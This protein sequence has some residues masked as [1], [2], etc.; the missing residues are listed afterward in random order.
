MYL[1]YFLLGV[2]IQLTFISERT[3]YFFKE[4][5]YLIIYCYHKPQYYRNTYTNTLVIG[6]L[7]WSNLFIHIMFIY[8]NLKL[9]ELYT[10]CVLALL[11]CTTFCT[12]IESSFLSFSAKFL[13]SC[14]ALIRNKVGFYVFHRILQIHFIQMSSA[15]KCVYTVNQEEQTNF[16]YSLQVIQPNNKHKS[17]VTTC[18][19]SIFIG[20]SAI[21]CTWYVSFILF[22]NRQPERPA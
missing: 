14:F 5:K 8:Y 17:K 18:R 2:Y 10:V 13:L 12:A 4:I 16:L 3:L 15:I 7:P 9:L 21:N 1:F 6:N 20:K 22:G 11:S 19:P